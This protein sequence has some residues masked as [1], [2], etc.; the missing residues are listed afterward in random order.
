MGNIFDELTATANINTDPVTQ[1]SEIEQHNPLEHSQPVQ[2]TSKNIKATTQE[3]LKFGLL[4]A[5]RKPNLYQTALTH[6]DAINEIFEP[7]DLL[8]KID[9]VRGLAYV[10]IAEQMFT[11][12]ESDDEDAWSHPLIRRQRLTLEQTLLVAILR[13]HYVAH[14]QEAGIGAGGAVIVLE[15]LMPQLSMYLGDSGS[16]SR[17]QKRL[18]N[19]LDNLKPHGI[20]SDIDNKDQVTIRPIITHLANPQTLQTLLRYI[21]QTAKTNSEASVNGEVK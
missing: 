13:Q 16:E 20:V 2:Y 19:L 5:D 18:R 14:E 3:L 9:D 8:L 10:V 21:E 11:T 17:D 12:S 4:E 1:E 7:L 6:Q 15:D